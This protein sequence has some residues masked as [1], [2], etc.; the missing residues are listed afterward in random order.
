MLVV[1]V[2]TGG[3]GRGRPATALDGLAHPD[4]HAVH[5][6]T[7]QDGGEERGSFAAQGARVTLHDGEVGADERGEVGLV[8]D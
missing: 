2:G 5:P 1:V 7:V 4:D 8:Y 6:V 3:G